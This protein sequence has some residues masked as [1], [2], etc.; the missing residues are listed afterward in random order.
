L[1]KPVLFWELKMRLKNNSKKGQASVEY[2]I[3]AALGVAL[4]IA[5]FRAF[6]QNTNAAA[7][8]LHQEAH[9]R[10]MDNGEVDG[11]VE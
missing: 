1:G 10:I 3:I 5:G 4:T 2:F 7:K 11:E 8:N 9:R 6:A